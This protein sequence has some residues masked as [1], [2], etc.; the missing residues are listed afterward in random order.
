MCRL[1]VLVPE[2][3]GMQQPPAP[4]FEMV[5]GRVVDK[6]LTP[7]VIE[8]C[9][10]GSIVLCTHLLKHQ[11]WT[12]GKTKIFLKDMALGMSLGA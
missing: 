10:Q 11:Q 8:A 9:K 3:V 2:C 12:V 4:H 6:S 1:T 5:D 7:A